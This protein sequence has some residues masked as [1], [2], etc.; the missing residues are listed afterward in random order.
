M[1]DGSGV[2]KCLCVE[3]SKCG[4]RRQKMVVASP[5]RAGAAAG[6]PESESKIGVSVCFTVPIRHCER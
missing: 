6:R 5:F 1:G 3:V 4:V 2:L